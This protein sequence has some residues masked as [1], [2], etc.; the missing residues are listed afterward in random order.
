[1]SGKIDLSI[2]ILNYNTKD[3]LRKC[4]ASVFAALRQSF[5]SEVIVVDNASADGSLGMVE[6]EFPQ[7]AL[8]KSH[9]NLG[10][11]GGNNLGI[12]HA[13][14]RYLLFLNSDTEIKPEALKKVITYMEQNPKVGALTP[15]TVLFSGGMDP[16]C[17]R[18]FPTPWASLTYFLGLEKI[19]PKSRFFGQYHQLYLDL[20][21]THEIDAGFGTFMIVR[22][23]VVEK[24]GGWDENYFFYGEDLDFFYRIKKAGWKV[25]FFHEPLV[26][27]HKGASSGLRRESQLITHAD[28]ETRMRTAKESIR[29]MEIFY[30]KY[31]QDKYPLWLTWV[32]I[33]SIRIKGF[34]RLAYHFFKR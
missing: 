9:K 15:K 8:I 17:H 4:L 27:H 29:A 34:L 14:G 23:E 32:V 3:L 6:K 25:I 21:T 11:A 10:F 5:S 2:I 18:G 20:D 28:R 1:M 33:F 24:I 22:K 16:D 7:A 13:Q 12:K 31:Y 26:T 30:E 19:F